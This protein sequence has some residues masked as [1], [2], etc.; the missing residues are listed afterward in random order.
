[1]D[2]IV[3]KDMDFYGYHGVLPEE[4]M[5]GQPFIVSLEM[6]IDLNP[7][8]V[9]DDL[10]QTVSYAEVYDVVK[11]IVE[12]EK[13]NLLERLAH[14]IAEQI[15]DRYD[16]IYNIKVIIDKP[17]APVPGGCPRVEILREKS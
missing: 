13:Y 11:N 9:S 10:T 3:I 16:D 12:N 14:V 6:A 4:K 7:A 2:K 15:L 5:V 17:E 8:G 1:M